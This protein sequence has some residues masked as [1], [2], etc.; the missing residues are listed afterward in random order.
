M[1][2][3]GTARAVDLSSRVL[4][5]HGGEPP[6]PT[7]IAVGGIHGNEPAGVIAARRVLAALGE[8]RVPF[9]G[10]FV[11][12]GGNLAA[13]ALG[14]R[15]RH[16]D[17]NR[18]WTEA[19]IA[20]LRTQAPDADDAEDAEQRDLL[21]AFDAV[22]ARA[23]GDVFVIDLH[24]TSAEGHPFVIFGDTMRQRRFARCFDLPIILGLE[25]QI[26][27]VLSDHLTRRGCVTLSVEGGRH[28]DPATL[29]R[30][31][32]VIWVA[33]ASVGL[34]HKE[35]LPGWDDARARL[36]GARVGFPPVLEVLS[37]HAITPEDQFSMAPGFSNLAHA[38]RGQLLARDRNGEIRAP[39]DGIV[40]LPL[41]QGQGDDGFFW[42]R[43]VGSTRMRLGDSARRLGL[44][45][46]LPY[47]P[48]VRRD[49]RH[50]DRLVVDKRVAR[51]YPLDVFHV[52]G[53][54]RI[55]ES[56]RT[57]TVARQDEGERLAAPSVARSARLH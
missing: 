13:L 47:L 22:L 57:L 26:D 33:L 7:L 18:Q 50:P 12:L 51:I 49:R 17:L 3:A 15:F 29:E 42:G 48:G 16:K 27:G 19:R 25:E 41:Y 32:A 54:R 34:C 5:Q 31:E 2:H 56:G 8:A 14:R 53:Y 11:A 40:I 46:V 21:A 4:G 9:R 10:E 44:D 45:R 43:A 6:G 52:F 30:L 35:D 1:N 37:R 55:R 39:R 20:A 23:Q 36:R 38:Q 28:D 24:T